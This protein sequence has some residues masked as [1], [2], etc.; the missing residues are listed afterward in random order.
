MSTNAPFEAGDRV[1]VAEREISGR[2]SERLS[3]VG[4]VVSVK[5]P[6]VR[7]RDEAGTIY[8]RHARALKPVGARAGRQTLTSVGGQMAVI[9]PPR[10]RPRMEYD[11]PDAPARRR[12]KGPAELAGSGIAIAPARKVTRKKT[13][14][15]LSELSGPTEEEKAAAKAFVLARREANRVA[16]KKKEA[17]KRRAEKNLAMDAVPTKASKKSSKKAAK[18]GS[19]AGK[20]ASASKVS[21][22][23]KNGATGRTPAT[24]GRATKRTA[25]AGSAAKRSASASRKAEETPK[26]PKKVAGGS[27]AGAKGAKS[28]GARPV[29]SSTTPAATRKR[30]AAKKSSPKRTKAMTGAA[31]QTASAGART[32]PAKRTETHRSATKTATA[33]RSTKVAAR[34]PEVKQQV[35]P[36]KAPAAAAKKSPSNRRGQASPAGPAAADDQLTLMLASPMPSKPTASKPATSKP[37]RAEKP[38]GKR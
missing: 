10:E 17:E 26:R 38:R 11:I 22:S 37:A 24:A 21:T 20:K 13:I 8:E 34:E 16:R 31:A 29:K 30:A 3:W 14:S 4:K 7:V 19:R 32:S 12:R 36:A 23:P 28:A 9:M 2:V 15:R 27:P 1:K 6:W 25:T 18:S 5:F 33:K 35:R